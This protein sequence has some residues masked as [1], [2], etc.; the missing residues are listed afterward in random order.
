MSPILGTIGAMSESSYRGNLDDY[1]N[2]FSF[3]NV[4]NANPGTLYTSGIATITGINYKIKVSVVG[5]GASFSVNGDAFSTSPRFMR[6]GNEI[7]LALTTDQD[8][9]ITDFLKEHNVNV[10]AGKRTTTWTVKTRAINH[11]LVPFNFTPVTNLPVGVATTSNS[12][13][14]SGLEPGYGLPSGVNGFGAKISINGGAL[15]T[16]GIVFNG[17]YFYINNPAAPAAE[18]SSYN[19]TRNISAFVGTYS[20]T[21]RVVTE[22]ADLTPDAFSFTSITGVEINTSFVSNS[23]T[24]SGINGVTVPKFTLNISIFG[25]GFEYS[26]NGGT[27][28]SQVG[29]VVSGDVIRLRRTTDFN[30]STTFTGT[31]VIG[32]VSSSWN[33]TTKSQPFNTIPSAF[34]FTSITNVARNTSFTSNQI[35]LGGMTPGF[36]GSASVS[37]SGQFRVIRNGVT[38]RDFSV[39]STN[40]QLGDVIAL[41]DTSS[42]NYSTTK[43]TNFTV[44]GLDIN[45]NPGETSALWNVTTGIAPILGCTDPNAFNYNPAATQDDGSCIPKVF[46]CTNSKALNY[47]PKAN[48]DDGTCVFSVFGCT[49]PTAYNYNPKATVDDGTCIPRVFGCTN[50]AA[51]NYNP[52]ANTDNGSCIPK[53]FGCTNPTATNYNPL[54]N[55]DNGT[56]IF[57]PVVNGCTDPTAYNYNPLATVDDGTCIPKVFGC[58][59]PTAYNYNPLANVNNGTC[60][61]KVFGCTDSTAF[62]YNPLANV[63]NGTCI[64]KVLGCTD[65]TATNYNPLANVNNGTCIFS[66]PGCTNKLATNY[67]PAATVDDGSCTFQPKPPIRGCT[68]PTATNYNPLAIIDDGSCVFRC[69]IEPIESNYGTGFVGYLRYNDLDFRFEGDFL[70]GS[71]HFITGLNV[72]YSG[73]ILQRTQ[74]TYQTVSNAI[75]NTY[76]NTIGRYPEGPGFDY[77]M[78]SFRYGSGTLSALTNSIITSYQSIGG[79]KFYQISRGRLNGNFDSCLNGVNDVRRTNE[80]AAIPGCI[81]PT[82][83]NYNPAATQDDGSC[84]TCVVPTAQSDFGTGFVG[85]LRY[86]N[87]EEIPASNG[88]DSFITNLNSLYTNVTTPFTTSGGVVTTWSAVST[89]IINH[90]VTNFGR[91]PEG[92]GYDYWLND[93][94]TN[95]SYTSF[96]SLAD[97]LNLSFSSFESGYRAGKG[98]LVGN[99]DFCN[100]KRV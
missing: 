92:V 1:A 94:I 28:T 25:S 24:V 45:G 53:V 37:G 78:N 76:L 22:S 96:S 87:G 97:A 15:D 40:V 86:G 75:I 20:T 46:G 69:H 63:N 44:S 73:T 81:T 13:S 66:I 43:T 82:A 77:W 88:D 72:A 67:N 50:P 71:R 39:N 33:V 61:P 99:Y 85:Y 49:D 30:Y 74:F 54:A 47:N 23:I 9:T 90:Y 57:T 38:V 5:A 10:T 83:S 31:L 17:N 80:I 26:K 19:Q 95:P 56:C 4:D 35:T 16:S 51:F 27:F 91:Y 34:S 3:I 2:D 41:R 6:N 21:W 29:T 52:L 59:D 8:F 84:T 100:G 7:R 11:N 42:S 60:I 14:I 64:P 18:Q 55:T 48:V 89:F 58:T 12:V 93:F 36:F 79:E 65:S 62:N 32:S 68:D 70:N 98:G